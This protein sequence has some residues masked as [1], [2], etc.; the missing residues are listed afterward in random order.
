MNKTLLIADDNVEFSQMVAFVA[1]RRGWIC[2]VYLNGNELISGLSENSGPA[3]LL[4][5][6]LMPDLDG[7]ETIGRLREANS[8]QELRIRFIT[9]GDHSNATAARL[10]AAARS[11]D[12]GATIYK[13]VTIAEIDAL[14]A[15]EGALLYQH[16]DRSV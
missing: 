15:E 3:L 14:L 6:I 10:I 12:V 9:G 8:T 16:G 11:F 7:I 1:T 5:D 4:L 13:P 2:S